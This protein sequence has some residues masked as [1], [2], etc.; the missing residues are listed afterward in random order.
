MLANSRTRSRHFFFSEAFSFSVSKGPVDK[1]NE[2]MQEEANGE[3]N[4][5]GEYFVG[6]VLGQRPVRNRAL[7]VGAIPRIDDWRIG[8]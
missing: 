5:P 8:A 3:L 6:L 4:Y 1:G 7:F 2:S